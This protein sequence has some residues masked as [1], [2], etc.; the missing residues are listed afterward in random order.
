MTTEAT[1]QNTTVCPSCTTPLRPGEKFCAACGSLVNAGSVTTGAATIAAPAP[2]V[3]L[4]APHTVTVPERQPTSSPDVSRWRPS[5]LLVLTAT[6][7]VV[8][9]GLLVANDVGAHGQ[10]STTRRHLAATEA[11]LASTNH[12]LSSTQSQLTSTRRELTST[13]S[14]LTSANAA[15]AQ[16]QTRL[17][18]TQ[19]ELAGVRGNLSNTQNQLNLQ[20]GQLAIV[21]ACLSGVATAFSAEL[22]GDYSA[23]LAALQSVDSACQEAGKLFN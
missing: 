16:L 2:F 11:S 21:K 4:A 18:S 17:N 5:R 8:V 7:I 3:S 13:K 23:G 15:K 9:I 14:S 12:K 1:P 19:D 6:A 22:N 20:A 10:L